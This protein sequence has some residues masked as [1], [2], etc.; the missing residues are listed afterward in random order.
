MAV[1]IS[2]DKEQSIVAEKT[3]KTIR[4]KALG[5][6]KIGE[7]ISTVL[8]WNEEIDEEINE[9]KKAVLLESYFN[10]VD[11]QEDAINRLKS[12][13]INPQGNVLFNKVLRILDDNPPDQELIYHLSSVLK[14]IISNDE[15]YKMFERHKFALSQIENLT[16]QALTILA[17]YKNYPTFKL[18]TSISFGPKVT[19]EW[20]VQ[21]VREYCVKKNITSPELITRISHVVTQLQTQGYIEAFKSSADT[22]ICEVSS[23]GKDLLPYITV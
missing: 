6:F 16:P 4:D 3:V 11:S 8:N 10:K 5:L 1:E 2:E 12:F 23:I 13:L 15:F 17:D 18:G 19:S 7:V 21:F 20:N 14:F 22:F 9:A